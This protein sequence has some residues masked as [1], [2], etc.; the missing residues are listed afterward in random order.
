MLSKFKEVFRVRLVAAMLWS[1]W[2]IFKQRIGHVLV[3]EYPK[4]GASWFCKMLSEA[5][6]LPNPSSYQIP[7]FEPSILHAVNFYNQR[8]GKTICVIRDGRDVMVSAYYFLLF[9]N[10]KNFTWGVER[11]RNMVPFDDYDNIQK[12]LPAFIHFMFKEYTVRNQLTTWKNFNLTYVD[13]HNVLLV[14]YEDMLKDAANELARALEFLDFPAKS[15]NFLQN[16]EQK[17]SFENMAKRKPGEE[18][19]RKYMRKGIAGDWK[20]K[21]TREASEVF[22]HYA[23][24]LLIQLGYEKNRNWY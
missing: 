8:F 13:N 1:M 16:I 3:A 24:D 22:D 14:K 10:D 18:N 6:G 11:Y 2:Y 20:N 7:K 19:T 4:S 12:N 15:R 5:T 23:G 9:K 17:Y 21:F